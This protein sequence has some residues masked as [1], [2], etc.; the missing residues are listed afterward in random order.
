MCA[1]AA[2]SSNMPA[3]IAR[4][5][6]LPASTFCSPSDSRVCTACSSLV[7]LAAWEM[8]ATV[9]RTAVAP[10]I[11]AAS[12]LSSSL[13]RRLSSSSFCEMMRRVIALKLS[14]SA[15]TCEDSMETVA[16]LA[17]RALSP[18][19]FSFTPSSVLLSWV[20]S[21]SFSCT[22]PF[23]CCSMASIFCL[24]SRA[25]NSLASTTAACSACC[26]SSFACLSASSSHCWRVSTASDRALYARSSSCSC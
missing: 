11:I 23:H 26:C 19:T 6:R 4:P 5:R 13:R 18:S 24:H 22:L 7:S 21:T 14:N 25:A 3:A 15:F 16:Y 2:I 8:E 20:T 17:E 1:M 10:A 9:P 12:A